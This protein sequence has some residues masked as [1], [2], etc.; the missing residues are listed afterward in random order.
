MRD[1]CFISDGFLPFGFAFL[2]GSFE[3]DRLLDL[4]EAVAGGL[5]GLVAVAL[6][7][8]SLEEDE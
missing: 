5:D 7:S 4:L 6:S 2:V 3:T 1:P 8:S